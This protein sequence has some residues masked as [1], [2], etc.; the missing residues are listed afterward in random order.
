M[1]KLKIQRRLASLVLKCSP[2]RV[3]FNPAML[4]DVKE[5]ITKTDMRLLSGQGGVSKVP[6]RGV[7]RGRARK[8]G[9]QKAK[10][11]RKG[12]GSRKGS[13]NARA[14]DKERW[15]RKVRSQREF[16][17]ELKE[18]KFITPKV[19]RELYAKVKG[20]YFRSRRHIKLYIGEKGLAVSN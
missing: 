6:A 14:S 7:S 3:R 2:K 9:V 10:G 5:A 20:N 8:A 15:M 11:L 18:K 12:H 1:M 17:A 4:E 16:I 19:Y 13:P